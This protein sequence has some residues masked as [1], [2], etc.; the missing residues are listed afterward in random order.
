VR[1]SK[2]HGRGVFAR[3]NFLKGDVLLEIDDSD[4]LSD[5]SKQV[6]TPEQ[7]IQMDVFIDKNGR[8]RIIFM[9]SPERFI[10]HSCD[11]NVFTRTHMK[12]GIRRVCALKDIR[13]G[14]ELT[15]DYALNSWEEW[16][17]PV[18]CN[19][20]SSNCR[21]IIRGNFFS[22]PRAIQLKYI[23]LLDEPFKRE[24]AN[25]LKSSRFRQS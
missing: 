14:E 13:K 17:I 22:L 12:S 15:W 6:L 19:C 23:P 9:K 25:I 21:K 5:R 16:E 18:K 24:I 7:E 1:K 4:I 11:P 2:I 10:N 3:K 20:G 8:E